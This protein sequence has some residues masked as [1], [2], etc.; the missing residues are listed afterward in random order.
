MFKAIAFGLAAGAGFQAWRVY[1]TDRTPTASAMLLVFLVGLVAAYCAGRGVRS[2][3]G[4]HASATAT[5]IAES[6]SEA[7]AQAGVQVN[8][9]Q[10]DPTKQA[11]VV[12]GHT[13]PDPDRVD[14]LARRQ[15]ISQDDVEGMDLSELV[16]HETDSEPYG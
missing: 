2:R 5:A 16:E 12:A 4:A 9:W 13:V 6:S 14:W 1:P 10:P 15:L 8:I 3:F 11:S 7:K